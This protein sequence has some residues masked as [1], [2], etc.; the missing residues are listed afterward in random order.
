MYAFGLLIIVMIVLKSLCA[1]SSYKEISINLSMLLYP[2]VF[3]YHLH[4]AR[5]DP[6]IKVKNLSKGSFKSNYYIAKI[7]TIFPHR[8]VIS[9]P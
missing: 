2:L 5:N 3:K 6:S 9:R 1:V 7:I 4:I 8:K